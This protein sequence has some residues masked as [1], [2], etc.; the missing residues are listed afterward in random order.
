MMLLSQPSLRGTARAFAASTDAIDIAPF[1][2]IAWTWCM[3]VLLL[4]GLPT[5]TSF[6]SPPGCL[7]NLAVLAIIRAIDDGFQL[8]ACARHQCGN[9]S[10]A[11][12][13]SDW[14]RS[15]RPMALIASTTVGLWRDFVILG[16]STRWL[17]I[18][19]LLLICSV[20]IGS[21]H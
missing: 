1:F 20:K 3:H 9:S 16:H 17:H 15:L 10:V 12:Q 4:S 18:P 19:L 21:E 13:R 7:G 11:K 14:N 6:F 2:A 8:A 5:T